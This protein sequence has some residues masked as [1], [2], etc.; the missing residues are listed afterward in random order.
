MIIACKTGE[1]FTFFHLSSQCER[2]IVCL[3]N[4]FLLDAAY[5]KLLQNDNFL[6]VAFLIVLAVATDLLD[7]LFP[8]LR[9]HAAWATCTFLLAFCTCIPHCV[10][11]RD[12][13]HWNP[14]NQVSRRSS[15]TIAPKCKTLSP[16]T[17]ASVQT[18]KLYHEDQEEFNLPQPIPGILAPKHVQPYN[19]HTQWTDACNVY[20][21]HSFPI[22]HS[23]VLSVTI[24]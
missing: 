8:L 3:S 4:C 10:W 17:C 11:S 18:C 13:Q 2:T 24:M 7:P 22:S 16:I 19:N 6:H 9:K 23:L 5:M 12:I 14:D 21:M 15:F 20:S 1:L